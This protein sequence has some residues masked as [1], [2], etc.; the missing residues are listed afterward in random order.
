MNKITFWRSERTGFWM[1]S[2]SATGLTGPIPSPIAIWLKLKGA[3]P[4]P[5]RYET[6][7]IILKTPT[8]SAL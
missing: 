1:Y 2:E 8:D 3:K 5:A 7:E 4:V 6:Y